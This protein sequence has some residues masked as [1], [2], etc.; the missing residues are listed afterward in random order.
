MAFNRPRGRNASKLQ[1][2]TNSE[3]LELAKAGRIL[4]EAANTKAKDS[5]QRTKAL[6]RI[7]N[8]AIM[9]VDMSALSAI[10]KE[11]YTLEQR[12]ILEETYQEAESTNESIMQLTEAASV[13]EDPV[14]RINHAEQYNENNCSDRH[15]EDDE[16]EELEVLSDSDN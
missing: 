14:E 11:Y 7:A 16:I 9:S 2:V 10:A 3:T 5:I 12:R 13:W 6:K 15:D 8:H 1:K 4:A